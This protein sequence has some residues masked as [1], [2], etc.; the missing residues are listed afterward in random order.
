MAPLARRSQLAAAL[1]AASCAAAPNK[2]A[3]TPPMGWMSWQQFRCGTNCSAYPA[4]CI[5]ERLYKETAD[6]LKSTGLLAAGYNT[7][8]L[9][10]CIVAKQRDPST[11][12]LVADP[13]RFPS[14]FKAL[15]DYLHQEGVEF[16][17]YTAMST[18]TCGGYPGSAEFITL[19]A[20][21]FARW[22]V[23]YLKVDGCGDASKYPQG[24]RAMGD[25]LQASG[26]DIVYSC[27]W[28]AYLGDDESEK[29]FA[30]FIEDGCNLWR[31][32][33]TQSRL[34]PLSAHP[35]PFLTVTRVP[36]PRKRASPH[37]HTFRSLSIWVR[38]SG[39]CRALS[40]TGAIIA[41][42]LRCGRGPD[43]GE[44]AK[45]TLPPIRPPVPFL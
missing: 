7:V 19:D 9:D 15:G 44:F 41:T 16:G 5:S 17:F 25:A 1:F 32:A 35:H 26:R 4:D 13:D 12:E 14:G 20:Q 38:R 39:T 33:R 34:P 2:L 31:N 21:T 37:T 10:D 18:S 42:R 22:G 29:P 28:P 40:S 36:G 11:N 45:H 8:H 3:R 27:S 6:A 24:Y 43:T 30:T 23:D